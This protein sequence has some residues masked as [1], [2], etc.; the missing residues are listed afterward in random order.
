MLDDC[1][2]ADRLISAV[3]AASALIVVCDRSNICRSRSARRST[4]GAMLSGLWCRT[5]ARSACSAVKLHAKSSG[6]RG[7]RGL[8]VDRRVD[9]LKATRSRSGQIGTI[10]DAT[11]CASVCSV[12]ALQ[13]RTRR[14]RRSRRLI[15]TQI[16]ALEL[17]AKSFKD[18]RRAPPSSSGTPAS[19]PAAPVRSRRRTSPAAPGPGRSPPWPRRRL[20]PR[21]RRSRHCARSPRD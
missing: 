8:C 9:R 16:V 3:S 21:G 7:L 6:L 17:H 20:P 10:R 12:V 4:R 11:R 18:G 1:C 5:L 15:G 13:E 14:A 2:N 19:C